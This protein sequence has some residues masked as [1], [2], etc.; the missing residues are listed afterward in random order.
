MIMTK[1]KGQKLPVNVYDFVKRKANL[2]DFLTDE[3]GCKIYWSQEGVYGK[4][5]CPLPSHKDRKP[6]FSIKFMNDVW[7]YKCLGCDSKGTIIDF[8]M[9]YYNIK[10]AA[11]SALFICDKLGFDKS[12]ASD[13]HILNE[14]KNK[15]NLQ[16]KIDCAH[17][18][19]SRQCFSLLKK[20]YAK[21]NKWVA[22]AYRKMNEALSKEDLSII[23]Q[24]G[25]E[26]SGKFQE[27]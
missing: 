3:L 5:I 4:C 8:C 10:N 6:S 20:D 24:I 16:K 12:E 22:C 14:S 2:A 26:A 15:A 27:K 11:L 19:A 1:H 7:V 17:V 18:I 21:Y 9:Q 25:Y 13:I 23:E